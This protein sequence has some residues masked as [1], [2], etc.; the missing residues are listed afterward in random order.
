MSNAKATQRTLDYYTEAADAYRDRVDHG[1]PPYLH[2]F[3]DM[4]NKGQKVLDL[5]CGPGHCARDMATTGLIVDATDGAKGMV[6]L[7]S[8]YEG[9]NAQ[10]MLFSELAVKGIYDAVWASFSL[11]HVPKPEFP[12]IL[13]RIHAALKSGG[14][15]C[16]GMKLDQKDGPDSL[17]RHYTYYALDELVG[18]LANAGFETF[19]NDF[20]SG[21][22]MAGIEEP[23]VVVWAH[24]SEHQDG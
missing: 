16:I 13:S 12:D 14:L 22:G 5:G 21:K 18:Y 2:D 11:L 20:G 23:W 19:R 8:Q 3:I 7:A 10:E 9:V 17:G 15:F 6:E 24:K 1:A 4:L